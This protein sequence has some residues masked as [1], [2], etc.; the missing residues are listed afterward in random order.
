MKLTLTPIFWPGQ[1]LTV[2]AAGDVLTVNGTPFDFSP[3]EPEYA[4]PVDSPFF[5]GDVSR[6]KAGQL[7]ITLCVPYYDADEQPEDRVLCDFKDGNIVNQVEPETPPDTHGADEG[8][9][10]AT[11]GVRSDPTP[12]LSKRRRR[13][14]A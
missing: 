10:E 5:A 14:V 4:V 3:L 1:N 7:H 2:D 13:K 9:E 6:D 11:S 8:T 12:R